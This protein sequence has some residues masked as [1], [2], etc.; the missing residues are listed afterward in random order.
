MNSSNKKTIGARAIGP[1]DDDTVKWKMVHEGDDWHYPDSD[2][3]GLPDEPLTAEQEQFDTS[4]LVERLRALTNKVEVYWKAPVMHEAADAIEGLADVER[5]LKNTARSL[6]D[7]LDALAAKD[8]EIERLKNDLGQRMMFASDEREEILKAECAAKDAEI[9]DLRD[10]DQQHAKH[11]KAAKGLLDE[12]GDI[13]LG[14][15]DE[16]ENLKALLPHHEYKG[17]DR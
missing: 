3:E 9:A 2:F 12:A 11:L 13:M 7:A 16:I 4:D 1:G 6:S 17:Q 10:R 14:M 8:A 15:R 5:V